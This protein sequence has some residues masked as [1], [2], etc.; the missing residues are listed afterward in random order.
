[1]PTALEPDALLVF[2]SISSPIAIAHMAAAYFPQCLNFSLRFPLHRLLSTSVSVPI[3][4]KLSD[5]RNNANNP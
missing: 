5:K 4:I 2:Q 1:M 3:A